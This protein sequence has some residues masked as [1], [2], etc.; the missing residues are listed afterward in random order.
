MM[1]NYTFTESSSRNIEKD[2]EQVRLINFRGTEPRDETG[3]RERLNIDGAI[4]VPMMDYFQAGIS[5]ELPQLI[6]EKVLERLTAREQEEQET[7]NA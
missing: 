1:N 3:D 5:G 4:I 7:E 6:K 2:G